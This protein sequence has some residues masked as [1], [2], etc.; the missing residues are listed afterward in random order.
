[1]VYVGV[2]VGFFS[3]IGESQG[4]YGLALKDPHTAARAR[5]GSLP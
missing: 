3:P 4:V 1:M 5:M 2:G